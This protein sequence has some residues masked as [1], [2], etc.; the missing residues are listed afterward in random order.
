V[1]LVL[2]GL[3]SIE[4]FDPP[5]AAELRRWADDP[6]LAAILRADP[7]LDADAVAALAAYVPLVAAPA[8]AEPAPPRWK[9]ALLGLADG[10]ERALLIRD[11]PANVGIPADVHLGRLPSLSGVDLRGAD[12]RDAD[13]YQADLR[14]ADL[15]RA[16]LRG[17]MLA[18]ANLDGALLGGADLAEAEMDDVVWPEGF[19]AEG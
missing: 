11:V 12:L 8:P 16:D 5:R 14:L 4:S 7:P 15:R 2:R 13:L 1:L 17:A 6:T 19:A 18:R 9:P 10:T 3:R